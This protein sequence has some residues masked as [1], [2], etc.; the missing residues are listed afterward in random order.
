MSFQVL[1]ELEIPARMSS[2]DRKKALEI[3][4][5]SSSAKILGNPYPLGGYSGI[6]IGYTTEVIGTGELA[7]L[8][9]KAKSQSETS[10]SSLTLGKGLYNNVDLFL[11]FAPFTQAEEISNFGGQVR[12]GFYQAEYMPAHLSLVVYANSTSFQNKIS[13]VSQGSDLVAGFSV[14]D[15]TLY[16]GIGMVRSIGTFFGGDGGVTDDGE[17]ATEDVSSSHYLAG[18][19]IKF[20]KAFLAMQLD[21]YS[22][23]TYSAKL[24]MR[25]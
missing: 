10:F 2:M 9:A 12:W 7:T 24:G 19:N 14:Q 17:T 6:E 20:S 25:F 18:I 4:G 8:G 22:Q 21:R 5:F 15:L 16:T 11:Q 3:L 1:A 23:S 13:T